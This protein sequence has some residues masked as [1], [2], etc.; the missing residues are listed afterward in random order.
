VKK[1]RTLL[2][3]LRSLAKNNVLKSKDIS[4]SKK[5]SNKQ[6]YKSLLLL[7]KL[8]L[9]KINGDLK[10]NRFEITFNNS[11]DFMTLMQKVKVIFYED[12]TKSKS[13]K[14]HVIALK[15]GISKIEATS[16]W[17]LDYKNKPVVKLYTVKR[18]FGEIKVGKIE[19]GI[20][21]LYIRWDLD[22]PSKFGEKI[23]YGFRIIQK[24]YFT[25]NKSETLEKYGDEEMMDGLQIL[26][27][28]LHANLE[29]KFP[30]KYQFK[31]VKAEK[32]DL[33]VID[34]PQVPSTIPKDTYKL[35]VEGKMISLKLIH[36]QLGYYFV[37]WKPAE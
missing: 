27:P 31:D 37:A 5:T 23:I 24:N 18:E 6:L 10:S 1:P 12:R 26:Y 8:N 15:D 25:F 7:S 4:I 34:G 14:Y 11:F 36:P 17:T 16:Y 13:F 29:V 21:K 28:T 35:T 2:A 9:I 30:Q 32:Y 20:Q 33:V 22:P 19:L 3:I